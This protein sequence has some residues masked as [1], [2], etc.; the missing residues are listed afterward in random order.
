MEHRVQVNSYRLIRVSNKSIECCR[1]AFAIVVKFVSNGDGI[2]DGTLNL[3]PK[4]KPVK[5]DKKKLNPNETLTFIFLKPISKPKP[6]LLKNLNRN[7]N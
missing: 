3:K 6:L 1:K 5:P 7:L 4:P 2:S